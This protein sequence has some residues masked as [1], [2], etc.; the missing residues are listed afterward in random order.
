MSS[1]TQFFTNLRAS[2]LT[3]INTAMPCK[4]LSFDETECTAKIQ[5]LYKVKEVG[6]D[7]TILPPI[8]G[9]PVLKQKYKVGGGIAQEYIPALNIGDIV[10]VVFC[11]RA[12]DDALEGKI[13][14]DPGSRMFSLK[15]AVIVG[16][17]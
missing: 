1:A 2:V 10:L 7:P 15:D 9:V 13:V 11:Q 12:I 8:E 17:F 6:H 5:P 16:V 3:S 14:D 4:V